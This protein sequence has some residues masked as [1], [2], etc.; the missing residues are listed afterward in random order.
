MRRIIATLG[1]LLFCVIAMGNVVHAAQQQQPTDADK[2]KFSSEIQ[3]RYKPG[4]GI[5]PGG[6]SSSTPMSSGSSSQSCTQSTTVIAACSASCS[7]ACI[8][9]CFPPNTPWGSDCKACV[10]PCMDKCTGCSGGST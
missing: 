8:F 5:K 6:S 9:K 2:K 4:L 7:A 3:Q 1:M 10:N